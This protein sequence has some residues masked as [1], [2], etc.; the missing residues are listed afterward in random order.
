MLPCLYECALRASSDYL[1]SHCEGV[2]LQ[3]GLQDCSHALGQAPTFAG[4]RWETDVRL[5]RL[6]PYALI[7]PLPSYFFLLA[8]NARDRSPMHA[9]PLPGQFY[10]SYLAYPLPGQFYRS[11]L[12]YP[13][14]GQFY[15]SYPSP[16]FT[17]HLAY[18]MSHTSSEV[19]SEKRLTT[20]L[21]LI[22]TWPASAR[23]SMHRSEAGWRLTH[24]VD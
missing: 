13:L 23:S 6:Q 3:V 22:S 5:V 11:Y 2:R 18:H 7:I 24:A 15:R 12:A 19:S 4:D 8:R 10:R 21:G 14:P 9:Y 1:D 20:R 16:D 17:T